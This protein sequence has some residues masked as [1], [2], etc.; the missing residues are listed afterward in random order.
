MYLNI[1]SAKRCQHRSVEDTSEFCVNSANDTA[2]S[3]L[4]TLIV[5]HGTV[6]CYVNDEIELQISGTIYEIVLSEPQMRL[7]NWANTR[8]RTILVIR[9]F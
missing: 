5:L 9:S 6:S 4:Y 3:Y 7:F 1:K 2:K 8:G